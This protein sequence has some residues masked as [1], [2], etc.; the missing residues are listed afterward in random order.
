MR[1]GNIFALSTGSDLFRVVV[2]DIQVRWLHAD[3]YVGW[4]HFARNNYESLSTVDGGSP[5]A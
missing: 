2:N 4:E 1:I 5:E 3:T